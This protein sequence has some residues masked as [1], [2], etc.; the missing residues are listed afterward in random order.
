MSPEQEKKIQL[1]V[2]LFTLI[3]LIIIG[4]M[5]TYFGRLGE[6]LKT[7]YEITV[8][9][10]SAAGLL[11]GADVL[12]AGAKI[13]KVAEGP[14][15]L[16]DAKGV[17]IKLK[18]QKGIRIPTGSTFTIGSSGLLGD[19]FV[20]ISMASA[21]G[22]PIPP[23]AVIDGTREM[24]LSDLAVEGAQLIAE[25]RQAISQINTILDRVNNELLSKQTVAD[26]GKSIENIRS[27]TDTLVRSSGQLDKTLQETTKIIADVAKKVDTLANDASGMMVQ[28]R[29]TMTAAK[30]AAKQISGAAVDARKLLSEA[31]SGKGVIAMLLSDKQ[32]AA[33]IR[34]FVEN[35]R[36]Y[37]ILFYKDR[38]VTV[39]P[40]S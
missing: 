6:G 14:R 8:R 20:D 30:D 9:Y 5:V 21:D 23:G 15:I 19:R 29:E 13:G 7:Y 38:A 25:A 22:P 35:L 4:S 10:P 1:R 40:G 33:Q 26:I 18:I 28:A 3:G 31:R 32:F 12:M 27:T 34:A 24:G 17:S 36:R 37:G 39:P 16:P 11:K 2:G